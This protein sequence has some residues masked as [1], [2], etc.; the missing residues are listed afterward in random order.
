LPPSIAQELRQTFHNHALRYEAKHNLTG[1]QWDQYSQ[2]T[3]RCQNA[4]DKETK[5]F[6]ERYH[7]RINQEYKKLLHEKTAKAKDYKPGFAQD[8]L[9]D[10]T[11]LLKQADTNVRDRHKQRLALI[12]QKETQGIE[13]LLQRSS[14]ENQ[15]TGQSK[16]AFARA[17]N[18]RSGQERRSR[19]Q[20][21]HNPIHRQQQ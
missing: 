6:N 9:L 5:L 1:R 14:R 7:G 8:D 4:S 11:A 18:R 21:T 2:L 12:E 3:E 20:Q 13:T 17:A 16:D 10:R 19:D 15:L